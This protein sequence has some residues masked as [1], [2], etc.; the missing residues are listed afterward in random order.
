MFRFLC[1]AFI[2]LTILVSCAQNSTNTPQAQS[3]ITSSFGAWF[4]H[5]AGPA[6]VLEDNGRLAYIYPLAYAE[7]HPNGTLPLS[8]SMNTGKSTITS[9]VVKQKVSTE[10]AQSI[11]YTF[12][13]SAKPK[14]TGPQ[15]IV[16][17]RDDAAIDYIQGSLFYRERM[18][19]PPDTMAII[20]LEDISK[21]DAPSLVLASMTLEQANYSPLAFSLPYIKADIQAKNRYAL[22][23]SIVSQ[24]K[25]LFNTTQTYM[26]FAQNQPA[27]LD[28]LLHKVHD[29]ANNKDNIANTKATLQNTYWTL[30][31]LR[32][33]AI[34]HYDHQPEAHLVLQADGKSTG[35]DGCN[36]FFGSYTSHG[37]RLTL[38]P[39][40]STMML[41]PQGGEQAASFMSGLHEITSY[42]INGQELELLRGHDVILTFTAQDK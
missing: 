19:L 41:C 36:R 30:T 2:S 5:D 10:E 35:S 13:D 14:L 38:H 23:A 39:G 11:V 42:K 16:Y 33:Q 26:V 17:T 15:G 3:P 4:S 32:G 37:H 7:K 24:G 22:R 12:T 25:L 28:M 21:A 29:E 1:T 20:T 9:R 40:G 8:W 18:M 31:N 6:L 34:E 27:C